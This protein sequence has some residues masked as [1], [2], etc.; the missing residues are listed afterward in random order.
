MV[1][2][3][4]IRRKKEHKGRELY[5]EKEGDERKKEDEKVS[6]SRVTF[7]AYELAGASNRQGATRTR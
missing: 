5:K 4:K 3:K 1:K 6:T 2:K 7:T